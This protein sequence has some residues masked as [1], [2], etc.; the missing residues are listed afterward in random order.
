MHACTHFYNITWMCPENIPVSFFK[1]N[2]FPTM[3]VLSACKSVHHMCLVPTEPGRGCVRSPGAGVTD[4]W[5][6]PCGLENLG[7]EEQPVSLPLS[8]P[9]L[10]FYIRYVAVVS[11][12]MMLTC[13]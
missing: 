11:M 10:S 12:L 7:S 4:D 9:P 2:L 5:E 6:L 8:A 1:T 13:R 3:G